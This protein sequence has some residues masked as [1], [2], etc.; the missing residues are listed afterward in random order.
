MQKMRDA[1]AARLAIMPARSLLLAMLVAACSS[2]SATMTDASRVWCYDWA[3]EVKVGQAAVTLGIDAAPA[4]SLVTVANPSLGIRFT[5]GDNF[6][7]WATGGDVANLG[8]RSTSVDAVSKAYR[9]EI[10]AWES[11]SPSTFTRVC[12]AAFAAR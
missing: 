7:Y 9:R 1:A 8:S 11:A 10:A 3:N 6:H 4:A 2:P 5:I 12:L